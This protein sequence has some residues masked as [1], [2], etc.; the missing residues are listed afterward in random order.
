M[1][2]WH[3]CKS[4]LRSIKVFGFPLISINSISVWK[5]SIVCNQQKKFFV[6][7]SSN[8][9][10]IF[11]WNSWEHAPS[12][13]WSLHCKEADWHFCLFLAWLCD[14][15]LDIINWFNIGRRNILV[16]L[17]GRSRTKHF[18]DKF[19]YEN[20]CIKVFGY[21]S[22]FEEHCTWCVNLN[23]RYIYIIIL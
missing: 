6:V 23:H 13:C 1:L 11:L 18:I 9:F 14:Y 10:C 21:F 19:P 5:D 3:F 4:K 22:F 16:S 20:P 8:F 7:S 15:L 17:Y 2:Q 12:N